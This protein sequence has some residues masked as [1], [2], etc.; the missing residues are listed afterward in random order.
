MSEVV[1][2]MAEFSG[3]PRPFRVPA[4][5]PRLVAPFMARTLA[6]QLSLSNQAARADLGWH[7]QYPTVRDGLAQMGLKTVAD[8]APP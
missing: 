6:M 5:L 4:W 1:Q 2:W 3:A 8:A 7:P